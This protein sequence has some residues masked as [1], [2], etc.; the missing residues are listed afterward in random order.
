MEDDKLKNEENDSQDEN[1]QEPDPRP[2][3]DPEMI[4]ENLIIDIEKPED[5]DDIIEKSDQDKDED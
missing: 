5:N 1:Y 2:S 3:Y 4:Y